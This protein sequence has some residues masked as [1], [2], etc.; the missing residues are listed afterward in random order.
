MPLSFVR[1]VIEREWVSTLDDLLERRLM[2]LFDPDLSVEDLQQLTDCLVSAG[3][4]DPDAADHAVTASIERLGGIF[5]KQVISRTP[6]LTTND[7]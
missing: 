7:G 5:G 4:I 2:L 6:Q 1:R 3:R